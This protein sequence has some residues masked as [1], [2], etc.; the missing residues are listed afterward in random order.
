[1]RSIPKKIVTIIMCMMFV[2]TLWPGSVLAAERKD[3]LQYGDKDEYV[4]E[5]Q[6]ALYAQNYMMTKPTG[7]FGDETLEAVKQFQ[8]DNGMSVDGKA[9][10]VTRKILLGPAFKDIPDTRV[11]NDNVNPVSD[12]V[13]R[14]DVLMLGDKDEYVKKLQNSLIDKGL[15]D[16]DATGYFGTATQAAVVEFQKSKDMDADGKAG[17]RTLKALWGSYDRLPSSRKVSAGIADK[18]CLGD[19]GEIVQKIQARLKELSYYKLDYVTEYFGPITLKAVETFQEQ[20]GLNPDGVVGQ[21]T[22]ATLMSGKAKSYK[23]SSGSGSDSS[24]DDSKKKPSS[25]STASTK[26]EKMIEY[27][28]NFLGKPYV[29]G[30]SGPNSFDCSGFTSYVLKHMGVKAPRSSIDQSRYSA[31]EAVS[32]DNLRAGD[33]VFFKTTSAAV[34]HVGIYLGGGKFIHASSGK[35]MKVIISSLSEGYYSER[36]RGGRR[37]F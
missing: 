14:T 18:Y 35:S 33:L 5:L 3:T 1:M 2:F 37:V 7:Y 20:N 28:K 6:K 17:P 13:V 29:Y 19:T 30:A 34:G 36:F 24:K 25:S 31:W 23:K 26:V 12:T 10:I 27:A 21:K 4:E 32:L 9:G 22:Y 16:T 15:L 11:V 8:K